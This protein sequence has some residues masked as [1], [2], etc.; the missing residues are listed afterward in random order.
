M[1]TSIKHF[2]YEYQMLDYERALR[3]S[4]YMEVPGDRTIS[5]NEY[6]KG[7][8]PEDLSSF[9]DGQGRYWI[10]YWTSG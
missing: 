1:H 2:D 6:R 9:S 5:T 10:E 4:R 8:Q 7:A 3:E